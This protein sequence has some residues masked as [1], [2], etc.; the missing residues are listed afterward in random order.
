MVN[1]VS[2]HCQL[3]IYNSSTVSTMFLVL[4]HL[5][6][7]ISVCIHNYKLRSIVKPHRGYVVKRSKGRNIRRIQ[8]V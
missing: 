1:E 4:H 3:A 5:I 7:N 2:V 6:G 8:L